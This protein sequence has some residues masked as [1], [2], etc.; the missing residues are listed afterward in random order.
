MRW[1]QRLSSDLRETAL[2]KKE[3][4]DDKKRCQALQHKPS[5]PKRVFK[6]TVIRSKKIAT[7]LEWKKVLSKN[8]GKFLFIYQKKYIIAYILFQ[9]FYLYNA[10]RSIRVDRCYFDWNDRVEHTRTA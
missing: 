8:R 4:K 7:I 6:S 9:Y 5:V 2:F 10:L 1:D 3:T